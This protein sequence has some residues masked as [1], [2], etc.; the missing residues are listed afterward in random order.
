[1][2]GS[3]AEGGQADGSEDTDDSED[4][5]FNLFRFTTT[6][7]ALGIPKEKVAGEFRHSLEDFRQRGV[8]PL[9]ELAQLRASTDAGTKEHP[10]QWAAGFA[11]GYLAAWAA[12]ILRVLD[13]RGLDFGQ[14]K[15]LFRPLN[16]CTDADLLTRFLDRAV[17]A[18]HAADLVAGEPSLLERDGS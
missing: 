13:T 10:A 14:D 1:M 11:A 16:L 3:E 17:T 18:T 8:L 2:G 7:L 15:H 12:A 9:E 5:L 6:C 4:E